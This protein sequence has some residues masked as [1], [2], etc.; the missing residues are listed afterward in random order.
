MCPTTV[1]A[2]CARG[3]SRLLLL[4]ALPV[5]AQDQGQPFYTNSDGTITVGGYGGVAAGAVT[6]PD[7]INGRAVACI[8]YQAFHNCTKLTSVTVPATV[9]TIMDDAFDWC[10]S[11]ASVFFE[12]DAPTLG[13]GV[14]GC[15][16]SQAPLC[17]PTVYYLPGTR[18]WGATFGGCPAMLNPAAQYDY[19]TVNGTVTVTA[20]HGSDTVVAIPST[21]NELPVTSI[22]DEAFSGCGSLTLLSIPNTITNIGDG[23][24]WDCTN[25]TAITVDALNSVYRSVAGVLF[26]QG[27]TRLIAYPEGRI[28]SYAIPNGV[29][30]IASAAF[31]NCRLTSVTIP[32]TVTSIGTNAFYG[33]GTLAGLYFRGDAPVFGTNVF[34]DYFRNDQGSGQIPVF[35]PATIYYLPGTTGW[36]TNSTGLPSEVWNAQVQTTRG[37]FGR[38][39]NGFGFT[40]TGTNGMAVVVESITNL[41]DPIWFPLA[42]NS[43]SGDSAYFSDPQWTNY[44]SRFYRLRMP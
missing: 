11:L 36:S 23:A 21:L 43:L 37:S 44:P 34:V 26:N 12:G 40:I 9:T 41:G 22:G 38:L 28:G 7:F 18:G 42:T 32:N 29:T 6:I 24:F 35:D 33:C 31:Y 20:Y 25:L 16:G 17:Y 15:P 4:L 2:T 3:L 27:Q 19:T 39:T 10:W 30:S 8:G 1:A 13:S 5:L 14:F